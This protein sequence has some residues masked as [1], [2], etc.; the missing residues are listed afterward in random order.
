MTSPSGSVA[1]EVKL[2]D[3][4]GSSVG[5]FAWI[6]PLNV[7]G[8]FAGGGVGAAGG[9]GGGAGGSGAATGAG[10]GGGTNAFT[11]GCQPMRTSH[12]QDWF[13]ISRPATTCVPVSPLKLAP[14]YT[15]MPFLAWNTAPNLTCWKSGIL[16]ASGAMLPSSPRYGGWR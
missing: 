11:P 16:L 12:P 7:G 15:N 14:P 2:V 6:G 1:G 10:G 9:G 4:P 13:V 3:C 8:R 5:G